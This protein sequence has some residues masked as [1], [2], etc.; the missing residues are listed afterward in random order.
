MNGPSHTPVFSF[1][2]VTASASSI[3]QVFPRWA[4]VLGLGAVRFEPLDLGLDSDREA[5]RSVVRAIRDDPAR[6][7]A[8]VTTHKVRLLD[9]AR[10]LFDGLDRYA[11]LLGEVSC[12]ARR[13]GRVTGHAKD[14]ITSGRALDDLLA[15]DHFRAT[16][17]DVVCLGAGGSGLAIAVHLMTGRERDR[18]GRITLVDRDP[19]RLAQCRTV[20]DSLPPARCALDLV[21]GDDPERN[22][23]LVAAA[24]PGSLIVNATGM[25]KDRPGAP[26]TD[27]VAFPRFAVVWELNY[28]GERNFLHYAQQEA[29]A[30]SLTVEDGWRYFI[31]GWSEVIA[32][33]FDIDLTPQTLRELSDAAARNPT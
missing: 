2:G 22:D 30:R 5:Y 24:A 1:V 21:A 31:H 16:G 18:P 28:R 9:A 25:G 14:P 20:L 32:E 3:N 33:V 11:E 27:A 8:L 6:R 19:D 10:D 13:D 26:V 15:H 7:G 23:A 17:G 12:I 29:A 4:E